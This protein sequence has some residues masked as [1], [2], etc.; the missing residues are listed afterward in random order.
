MR[1][2][3][4]YANNRLSLLI[5]EGDITSFLKSSS[6]KIRLSSVRRRVDR[7]EG[8][9]ILLESGLSAEEIDGLLDSLSSFDST[10]AEM[11]ID[12]SVVRHTA[13]ETSEIN[14]RAHV[15]LAI[16]NHNDEVLPAFSLYSGIVNSMLKR[17]LREQQM[18]D[19]F[20]MCTMR[21]S[22]NF[23]VPGSGKTA[24]VLGTYAYLYSQRLVKRI[25]VVCPKNAFG[26]W[27]DEWAACLDSFWFTSHTLC[28][29]DPSFRSMSPSA[30]QRE[31]ALN[32]SR[33]DLILLNYEA[34]TSYIDALS[35][36][37]A[38]STLLVFDEVH[39][40][41]R[42]GGIRAEAALDI[43]QNAQYA[44]ALT[45]TPIPNSYCDIYNLLHILY[46]AEYNT[47][48]GFREKMLKDPSLD[49]IS[50]INNRLQPFFCR[51]NKDAL[52][53]PQANADQIIEIDASAYENTVFDTLRE[54]YRKDP[55]ALII[56]I[57]QAES[58][59]TMLLDA[60]DMNNLDGI[61]DETKILESQPLDLDST[62]LHSC[63]PTSKTKACISLASNLY[64][65]RKPFI[66]WCFFKKSMENLREALQN[67][68]IRVAIIN[69]SVNQEDRDAI[70]ASFKAG[71]IDALITNPHTLAESV[72][73][74]HICHD[75]IYFE[76]SYNLVHLLQ[77]KDRIHRLGLPDEQYT[78]YYFLQTFY[79]N[80]DEKWSLDR[81]IYGRLKEKEQTMADAID[82]GVLAPGFTDA[83]DIEIVFRGL[84]PS[85]A[86]G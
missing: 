77:S 24:S 40:V 26:S 11:V 71:E 83:Q 60:L 55:L 14:E 7:I 2:R 65:E 28:I 86:S 29:H 23:S 17:P 22:A 57:L 9:T 79:Q 15:G 12:S 47:F 42:I 10:I 37:I 38:Q 46:P 68:G 82:K 41:K 56:R 81:N 34:L 43:A 62:M 44:I 51:T 21:K 53:V 25:V 1:I 31:L 27:R 45:G 69:G 36:L 80:I 18:W 39:K 66:I 32:G 16:K 5:E 84:F 52:G 13:K 54:T 73:L 64:R 50:T 58:D 67:I 72:S 3:A 78:Q 75:A 70:L 76:Y 49:D 48:F 63:N 20:F 4:V 6:W 33:Y 19:S 35:S 8:N 85:I 74:H 30:Q 59:P 61:L